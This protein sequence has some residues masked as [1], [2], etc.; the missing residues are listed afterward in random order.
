MWKHPVPI[1]ESAISAI[2][3]N[4]MA[5]DIYC[6]LAYRLHALSKPRRVTWTSLRMQFSP[7]VKQL[8]HFRASFR[9]N[10]ALALA[11]YPAARVDEAETGLTLHPAPRQ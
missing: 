3:N 7:T 8:F 5:L 6:W 1:E 4:S 2:K 10:L 9:D 11:V